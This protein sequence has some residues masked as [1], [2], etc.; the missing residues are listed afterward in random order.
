MNLIISLLSVLLLLILVIQC[1]GDNKDYYKILELK[2][3]ANEKDIKKSYRKLA[4]KW[5][6][7]KHS[8][9]DDKT[10]AQKKFQEVAEAYEVLSDPEKRRIFDQLGSEGLKRGGGGGGGGPGGGGDG[11]FHFNFGSPGNGHFNFQHKDPFDMFKDFFGQDFDIGTKFGNRKQSKS[12]QKQT[13]GGGGFDFGGFDFGNVFGQQKQ[14]QQQQQRRPPLYSSHDGIVPLSSSKFPNS[15][16]KYIWLVQFYSDQMNHHETA[17][18]KDKFIKLGNRLKMDGIKT[19]SVN[20]DVEKD[21]CSK[22]QIKKFPTFKLV[23]GKGSI[24]FDPSTTEE[25][26]LT[27]KGLFQFIEEKTPGKVLNIRHKQQADELIAS[28]VSKKYASNV[29]LILFTQKFETSLFLKSLSHM[30][31]DK[32]AVGEVRGSNDKLS[33]EFGVRQYPTLLAV[34]GGNGLGISETYR[35]NLKDISSIEKFAEKFKTGGPSYCEKLRKAEK[36]KDEKRRAKASSVKK[37]G[38][39][40][41]QLKGMKITELKE[42]AEDLRVAQYKGLLEKSDYITAILKHL[43]NN[44]NKHSE[45]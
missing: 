8:S 38:L 35:G 13:G 30:F 21:L 5:H 15:K 41:Q 11:N 19:G 31:D 2:R 32:I 12:K 16:S 1:N 34:C 25:K 45:L 36:A 23:H 44:N 7:D 33:I 37:N 28:L 14:Q 17:S 29:A 6:P 24:E 26:I 10:K 20:C 42:L 4:L 3:N 43:H 22:N 40:E 9:E 27:S 39:T 18:F